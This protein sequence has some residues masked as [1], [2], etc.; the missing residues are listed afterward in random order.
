MPN[1]A[2]LNQET[3]DKIA[4][5]EV[6][7][8]PCSVVKELVENAIDAGSTAITVE[9]KEGGIS[10]IR[11]TDNGCGIERDQVAVAFY[12]HSTSKIRSA[13]DLLTVKSL[14]FRGEALSSISAVARVELITKTYDELTGTRYVI[15]GSKE[16]SNEEIG[17]PDGTTF[18]VKDLFYNVPARR[19][20][21]KT[22][23]TEGSY[24]SDMVE[25]LALS[26]PDISF[27]F[28]NNNQTKLHTSGNGNRKDI[29]YHIF[30][31]EISSSLLEVKHE[32]E[33][34]KVE[35]FIGKPVITRGNRNYENYF[36]NGRY[37]KSN[38]LSRAIE[39]AYKSFLM[40][41]QYPFTVLYFTFFSELDV[42]VHPTKMELRFD[43]NN[44]IYVE[45]C[46]TIYAI[47]SHKEM[48]PE[49]PVDSTPAPKKI[50]HEY[51][52][53]IPEP[54]EKRRIN[55][56]RAAESRSV[57]GQSVTSAAK[58]PAVNE[59]LTD[60][61]SKMQTAKASAS[62]LVAGTGNSVELTPET[63]TAYEP[64]QVVTGTQQTLGDYDKVFLTESSKKQF[65]IIG[66]LFKTYWLIEF[67]DKLYIIDQHAA[68][69]KVLYEKTM[70]RLANKD[71]TSQRI[72]PP[73]VMTLDARE[74]EMLE[75]YRPQ[76]E[77]F[78]YE[79]E[80]FGGKE[81]MISAIPDNLF[82]ID[83]KDLFIEMLD[84]FSNA[85]GRQTPDIITEKVASMSCKAAVKGND[86]LTLPEINKLIDELL[87]LDNP[88][89]C[90]HG[91]PT[92]ISMSKYEIEKKFK[93]IV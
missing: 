82:N 5:G 74:C 77:Q 31:R 52:E 70:A 54:F 71:F 80:H 56:V 37:V 35:G 84:D 63:S 28:I 32:C 38:I 72:S 15:E 16:L 73:I 13:E 30:G 68:H 12:R 91:R 1:I 53:P 49:V 9:I 34:F 33:Y 27:K 3:I 83:M 58:A 7:E 40:Q 47:L 88:Y 81:Y 23:Q 42:N 89:N 86:K 6:V 14:G 44:E 26:H 21:L 90:P 51:K 18:I 79:V 36:I 43:N 92:I 66:Q 41:H 50:V 24:I 25:K 67:E 4:A 20:F 85:T 45:L 46:D 69:E 75:K 29:I 59:Q 65:S 62:A 61:T 87:S 64:A 11:I 8:R 19:K 93:R 78:G 17:A 39:E 55:E 10:F 2:I 57:Y 76:I 48:I 60:N 22:A